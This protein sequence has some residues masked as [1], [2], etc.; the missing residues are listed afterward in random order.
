[1]LLDE[2]NCAAVLFTKIIGLRE[3]AHIP[4]LPT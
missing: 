2:L 3:Q 1:M 4:G